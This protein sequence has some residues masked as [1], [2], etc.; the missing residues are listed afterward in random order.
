MMDAVWGESSLEDD[1]NDLALPAS[2]IQRVSLGKDV[3]AQH[4]ACCGQV[5]RGSDC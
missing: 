5:G 3:T 2:N 4:G 1:S